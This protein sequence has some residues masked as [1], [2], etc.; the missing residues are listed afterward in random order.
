MPCV[1]DQSDEKEAEV[2]AAE[3]SWV[4]EERYAWFNPLAR[5]WSGAPEVATGWA[6]AGFTVKE[7]PRPP[8]KAPAAA[9]A[10]PPAPTRAAVR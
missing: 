7:L 6:A 5:D 4:V 2:T 10:S 9:Q 8:R 1:A 3:L